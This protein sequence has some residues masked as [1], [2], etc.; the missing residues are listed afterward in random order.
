M[1]E[2]NVPKPDS[3]LVLA[4]ICT[5]CCC[6]PFGI[7]GIIKASKVNDYYLMKQYDAARIA[8]ED[9]KKWSLIGIIL[10]A[11]GSII[12]IIIYALAIAANM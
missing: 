8:A 9:A 4:I 5:V 11:V 3:N 2:Q 10:G 6:L 7:V 12:Y 1:E